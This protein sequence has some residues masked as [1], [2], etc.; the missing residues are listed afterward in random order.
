[1]L[2]YLS[3]DTSKGKKSMRSGSFGQGRNLINQE[4]D[5]IIEVL[6]SQERVLNLLYEKTFPPRLQKNEPIGR[7]A[8]AAPGG[9]RSMA[10]LTAND[11]MRQ[12]TYFNTKQLGAHGGDVDPD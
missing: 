6:L 5:K 12:F 9:H 3:L 10:N 2:T 4:R 11:S 1:M 7:C 8:S